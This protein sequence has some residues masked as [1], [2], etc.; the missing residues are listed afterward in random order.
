MFDSTTRNT[1]SARALRAGQS[2]VARERRHDALRRGAVERE[3]AARERVAGDGAEHHERVGHRGRA[4]ISIAGG[5]RVGAGALRPHAQHAARIDACDRAAAR[6]HRVHVE[7]R[8]QHRHARHLAA[9]APRQAV[10]AGVAAAE[11]GA[12]RGRAADVER[13]RALEAARA[14]G[15]ERRAQPGRGPGEELAH[16]LARGL[17]GRGGAAVGEHDLDF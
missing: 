10:A 2:G 16:G 11:E 4:G 1:P 17:L 8:Q 5:P 7:R 14:R 15:C 3:R 6:A 12:V 13:E 9:A